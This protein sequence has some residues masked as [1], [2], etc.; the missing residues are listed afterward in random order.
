VEKEYMALPTAEKT[1]TSKGAPHSVYED[2][3][4]EDSDYF[5]SSSDT[6]LGIGECPSMLLTGTRLP[7]LDKN[8]S[9]KVIHE[10]SSFI[11]NDQEPFQHASNEH[12]SH[13]LDGSEMGMAKGGSELHRDDEC[14]LT[15]PQEV[16]EPSSP[17][18]CKNEVSSV[19]VIVELIEEEHPPMEETVSQRVKQNAIFFPYHD[20]CAQLVHDRP[21]HLK[22]SRPTWTELLHELQKIYPIF[23]QFQRPKD[24]IWDVA[25]QPDYGNT[26][27]VEDLLRVYYNEWLSDNVI[28]FWKRR[29]GKYV[30]MALFLWIL[31]PV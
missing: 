26:L 31:V 14:K 28:S 21:L 15:Q 27:Y 22:R 29:Y 13:G 2:E 7:D 11:N 17:N 5:V 12:S 24:S 18:C 23:H 25:T 6:D 1:E 4:Y 3:K 10:A 19:P 30:T 8:G 9:G 20:D 16:V